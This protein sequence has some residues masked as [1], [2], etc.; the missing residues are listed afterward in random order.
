MP[1]V[2]LTMIV[3]NEEA[4][5]PACLESAT[6]LFDEIVVVD[7]GSTDRTREVAAR[8][9]AK[10]FDFPWIDDFAAA[11]NEALQHVT[12]DWIF[13]LDAGDRLDEAARSDLRNLFANL[14]EENV[15]Y[16]MKC[17]CLPDAT[18]GSAAVLYHPRLFRQHPE[19]RWQY[20]VH[21]QI[22][23][24]VQRQGGR[25][26][27]ANV[28]IRHAG[29]QDPASQRR[30][31]E[32]NLALCQRDAAEHPEDAF[33]LYNL[34]K[35]YLDLGRP[36]QAL[37]PLQQALARVQPDEAILPSLYQWLAAAHHQMGQRREALDVCRAGQAHFAEHAELVF[38]EALLLCEA[39]EFATAEPLLRRLLEM[40]PPPQPVGTESAGIRGHVARHNL[41][42]IC[43]RQ[44]RL[45]EAEAHWHAALAERPDFAPAW[46]GLGDLWAGQGRLDELERTAERLASDPARAVEAALLR[47]R[48]RMGVR[49]FAAARRILEQT[50][51][52]APHV[53]APRLLLAHVLAQEGRDWL[54]LEQVCRDILTL[55]PN[56]AQAREL[57]ARARR[58]QARAVPPEGTRARVSLTMIVRNEEARLGECLASTAGLFDEI[59]IVDTGSNDRTK[60][61]ALNAGAR[62]FDFPW[63]DDFAA[64]RN[65]ALKHTTGDYIF[66][67][68]AD[69]RL[70]E[71]ARRRLWSLFN[72]LKN[73]NVAYLMQR[74]GAGY[75][76]EPPQARLFR[77]HA[78]VR[79]Q[80]RVHEQILPSLERLGGAVRETDVRILNPGRPDR[81]A[82]L[83]RLERN[84]GLLRLEDTEHPNDPLTQFHLGC[85]LHGL[86]RSA[87]AL[88]YLRR[89]L[90]QLAP[91]SAVL[92][93]LY[94]ILAQVHRALGQMPAA[95]DVCLRGLE[96]YPDDP[97]L[98]FLNAQL[99][100][101][102]RDLVGAEQLLRRLLAPSGREAGA[103]GVKDGLRG[104]QARDLLAWT[105]REQGRP[106]E[107]EALWR[108]AA[109]E[110]P[111]STRLWLRMADLYA[112]QKRWDAM[113]VLA[114]RLEGEYAR[115]ADA[116]L[117]R[118]RV[119]AGR[120]DFG[121]AR[122]L[123]EEAMRLAPGTIGPREVRA[124]VLL[125]EGKDLPAAEQALRDVMAL[126][127]GNPAARHRLVAFL[128]Q[129]GRATELSASP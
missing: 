13:C 120:Q 87:E 70:D 122:R 126:D 123:A 30:K 101:D 103:A 7:T 50:N 35:T 51:A 86:G 107:A 104:W 66:W 24:S 42:L 2:S 28:V 41:A 23:P 31:L 125:L 111:D 45:A 39:G 127:P 22:L 12:G 78:D 62:V 65:E 84:L 80:Y 15:A 71:D 61:I 34:G 124:Q 38:R 92:P 72:S 116:A 88:P 64:A 69:E 47:A 83:R 95:T 14:G 108:Q 128:A 90:E 29:Q 18:T 106:D 36:D 46:F 26:V 59:I 37:L 76:T 33:V 81:A 105:C 129:T 121:E 10:V 67:L 110:R 19:I 3:K 8:F 74:V 115:P 27:W 85:T 97:E 82:E 25:L 112:A 43:F 57:L 98:L 40:P 96:R 6:G 113:E 21:E 53:L 75:A 118:A 44:Q 55:V 100:L 68:D 63:S 52:A 89:T 73:E 49:D 16:L 1:R 79:W 48:G 102:R 56:H 114:R 11:R 91:E 5:L 20:R 94:A 58:E 4:S 117:V 93:R 17:V 32:R 119:H 77:K 109:A 54:A 99:R 60:E 9:G